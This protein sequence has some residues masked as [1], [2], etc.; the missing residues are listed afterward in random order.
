MQVSYFF[1]IIKIAHLLL[2]FLAFCLSFSFYVLYFTYVLI[3]FKM[4]EQK[5]YVIIKS[6][7]HFNLYPGFT[8]MFII[9]YRIGI[10][11]NRPAAIKH[12]V[13]D[14]QVKK[15]F[16]QTVLFGMRGFTNI[17]NYSKLPVIFFLRQTGAPN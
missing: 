14:R 12:A 17:I 2:I 9:T 10:E 7:L 4:S 11:M 13:R 6:K 3:T 15:G 8:D 5:L 1:G 16:L